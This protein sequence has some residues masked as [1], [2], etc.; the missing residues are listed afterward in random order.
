MKFKSHFI[1]KTNKNI[2]YIVTI[3]LEDD[4]VYHI[5]FGYPLYKHCVKIEVTAEKYAYL[6]SVVNIVS[7]F[8]HKNNIDNSD[9]KSVDLIQCALDFTIRLFPNIKNITL[10]D[11]STLPCLKNGKISLADHSYIKHG[12]TWYQKN[13]GAKPNKKHKNN[14]KNSKEGLKLTLQK[15]IKLS[16]KEFN[17]LYLNHIKIK[18]NMNNET[19]NNIR[20][21][22]AIY[23]PNMTIYDYLKE[24]M[25]HGNCLI[26]YKFFKDNIGFNYLYGKEWYI[27]KETIEFY[28]VKYKVHKTTKHKINIPKLFEK[29]TDIRYVNNN[30]GV[31][32]KDILNGLLP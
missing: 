9:N 4:D 11:N 17:E 21:L 2:N 3:I 15:K 29:V 6:E 25:K 7:C 12:K 32:E 30:T 22:F 10:T 8:I 20:E 16:V 13:F 27:K 1:I 23:K 26:Y 18:E 31:E 24:V 19:K 14:I 28:N 5:Y